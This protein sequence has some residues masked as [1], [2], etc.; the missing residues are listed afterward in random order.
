MYSLPVKT[1]LYTISSGGFIKTVY[2][3]QFLGAVSSLNF[4]PGKVCQRNNSLR[5]TNAMETIFSN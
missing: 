1:K 2:E 5:F 3:K 4:V